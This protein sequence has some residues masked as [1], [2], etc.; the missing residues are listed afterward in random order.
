MDW[1]EHGVVNPIKN[2]LNCGG[3]WAFATTASGESAYA[4]KTGTLLSFS[5]QNLLDCA[6]FCQ[7]C[8]G[9]W[10]DFAMLNIIYDQG[11][12]FMSE[13]DYPYQGVVGKCLYDSTKAVG[14]ITGSEYIEDG[15]ENDLKEKVATLGVVT[16]CIS[17][18][19]IPFMSYTSGILDDDQ[20]EINQPDHAVAVVGYGSENGIDFWIVRNSWGDSWG[21]EG[22]VRM[23]RNKGNQC[24]IASDAV[25]D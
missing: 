11:G 1:R 23:S 19:N 21:E 4:I 6:D 10:P 5:E 20:C 18:S 2:Q 3:C 13:S 22:Y 14:E 8:N 24:G 25:I 17:A 12:H 7:G 9:G 16:S 15:D